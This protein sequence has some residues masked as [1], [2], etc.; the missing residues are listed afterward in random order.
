MNDVL[1][2]SPD[3]ADELG[4]NLND[5]ANGVDRMLGLLGQ[6]NASQLSANE[7]A[8]IMGQLFGEE[9]VRQIGKLL[10]MFPDLEQAMDDVSDA[11]VID[12]EDVEKM[13]EFSA[14]TAELRAQFMGWAAELSHIVTPAITG[15]FREL[16]DGND[17]LTGAGI[18]LALGE[19]AFRDFDRTMLD[20]L[21]TFEQVHAKVLE[22]TDSYHAA[23]LA[24]TEWANNQRKLNAELF[25]WANT[26]Q[27][28]PQVRATNIVNNII[29]P[30]GTPAATVDQLGTYLT[31]N[32]ARTGG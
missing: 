16:N 9:G 24:A 32:S 11:Q 20:G 28:S 22:V 3:L 1:A 30:P 4:I 19:E 5:G 12:D 17:S 2:D 6:L 18:E 21:D 25:D 23:N 29:N 10:V 31:R 27:N 26:V 8:R 13:R 15:F 7:K 14:E